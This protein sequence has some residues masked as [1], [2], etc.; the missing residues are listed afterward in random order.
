MY[1]YETNKKS[2]SVLDNVNKQP[3]G[4]AVAWQEIAALQRS[5][6]KYST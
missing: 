1:I 5:V 2:T 6:R 4:L 3:H